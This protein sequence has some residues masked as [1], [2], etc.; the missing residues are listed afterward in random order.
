MTVRPAFADLARVFARI[1]L[2]SFGG[3]AG[4]IALMHRMVVEERGWID[5]A[6]FLRALNVCTLLPG[7]EAQQLATYIGWKL[8]GVKGGLATGLLF[9]VPG[10]LVML[11]LSTLYG[12]AAGI[13]PIGAALFG[14]KAAVLA[15]IVQALLRLAARALTSRFQLGVA[16]GAFLALTFGHWP[17]P[18][19]IGI[20][21]LLGIILARTA[22]DPPRAAMPWIR[23][24]IQSGAA[25]VVL[26]PIWLA[27]LAASHLVL[28]P[29]HVLTQLGQLFSKLAMVSFGGAY[30]VLA[31]IA[32]EAVSAQGW[33]TPAEMVDGLG[34]A[35]TTPGPLILVNSFVGFLA[36]YRAP[37]PFLPLVA[38]VLGSLM[39]LW[40]T[41]V[42]CFLWIFASAPLMDRLEQSKRLQG[43]L[44]MIT[45]AVVGVMA[46]LMLWFA[47]HVVFRKVLNQTHGP[48][49]LAVPVLE[50]ANLPAI[51][52][53]L[54]AA[55]LIF[56]LKWGVVR[57][58]GICALVGVGVTFWPLH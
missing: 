25:I 41:F 37:T 48:V 15:I 11:G 2:I 34:L 43:A 26:V 3:P 5:D 49:T 50:S 56:G 1:G 4:Q 30:A 54:L 38:G 46:S 16:I 29:G 45:A 53:A 47:L 10:A 44:A 33:L 7:P 13:G 6:S 22:P 9:I 52:I 39:T 51:G 28:G 55:G 19:V 40:A 58:L 27:P 35:E 21:A 14:I 18:W 42:P 20:A 32:Q 24:L 57:C 31:Y 36:A 17:F 12:L 8:H 23:P